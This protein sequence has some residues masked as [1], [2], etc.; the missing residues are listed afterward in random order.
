[1]VGEVHLESVLKVQGSLKPF[2]MKKFIISALIL[3]S[4]VI[5]I[6]QSSD[7]SPCLLQLIVPGEFDNSNVAEVNEVY[8]HYKHDSQIKLSKSKSGED[9]FSLK[10]VALNRFDEIVSQTKN[11]DQVIEQAEILEEEYYFVSWFSSEGD[12]FHMT[13]L[14]ERCGSIYDM[15]L[16]CNTKQMDKMVDLFVSMIETTATAEVTST[17]EQVSTEE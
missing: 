13:A 6:A 11:D 17:E 8:T 9:L 12:K 3:G 14:T 1:M 16:S 10:T 2:D 5:G 7:T 4:S 15:S